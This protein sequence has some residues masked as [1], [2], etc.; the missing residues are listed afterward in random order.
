M[1]RRNFLKLLAAIPAVFAVGWK[2]VEAEP[3]SYESVRRAFEKMRRQR[4]ESWRYQYENEP[5]Y[6]ND[7]NLA[8]ADLQIEAIHEMRRKFRESQEMS[9]RV[10]ANNSFSPLRRKNNG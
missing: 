1:L 5:I 6:D 2:T 7:N 9:F 10:I 3:L 8:T 4:D